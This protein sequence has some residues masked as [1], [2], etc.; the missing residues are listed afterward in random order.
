MDLLNQ[1]INSMVLDQIGWAYMSGKTLC[2]LG[3]FPIII[4]NCHDNFSNPLTLKNLAGGNIKKT[5][6][7][8]FLQNFLP[9][10]LYS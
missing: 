2:Y 3:K 4:H 9:R 5:P 7:E 1:I 10:Y 8:Y 6:Q